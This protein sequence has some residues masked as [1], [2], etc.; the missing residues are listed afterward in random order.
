[1]NLNEIEQAKSRIN[2]I[3]WKSDDPYKEGSHRLLFKEFLRRAA[4]LAEFFGLLDVPGTGWP[5]LNYAAYFDSSLELED[6]EIDILAEKL[7]VNGFPLW[8]SQ[9][10]CIYFIHWVTIQNKPE[11][12]EKNIP[13]PYE[14]L[15]ILYERGGTFQRDKIGTWEF[16]STAF[17]IGISSSHLGS[18][19]VV[20]LDEASLNQ[21]D[22]DFEVLCQSI[23]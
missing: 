10:V 12:V 2:S 14:P 22:K 21:A 15:L 4:L 11:V 7:Q 6:E 13:N 1:M 17:F 19:P 23:L 9:R 16:S 5:M 3:N 20:E 18:T 8:Y